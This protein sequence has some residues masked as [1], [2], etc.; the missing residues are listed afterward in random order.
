MNRLSFIALAAALVAGAPAH[1][2]SSS[3]S[4][5]ISNLSIQLF[6]LDPLDGI[7]PSIAFGSGS[8]DSFVSASAYQSSPYAYDYHE[9]WGTAFAPI[10]TSAVAGGTQS[11]A[12]I[13]GTGSAAGTTLSASGSTVVS[14]SSYPYD[15]GQYGAYAY[16]PYYYY[17]AFTLSA[18]T[19][20]VISGDASVSAAVDPTGSAY[21]YAYA[22]AYASLYISGPAA[23]G[24][25]GGQS[26]SDSRQAYL[27]NYATP[28]SFAD[29]GKIAVSFVNLTGLE[30]TGYFQGT[31]SAYG[32]AYAAAVPEPSGYAL[33][34]AGLA[35]TGFVARR[36]LRG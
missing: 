4:A 31:A 6:D 30:T 7:A 18:N 34:L 13:I 15:N 19:V 8:T 32:W 21:G 36:R 2:G 16:T 10:A 27:Y 9:A 23:G 29:A 12:A 24:G 35:A 11:Q 5:T 3:A 1:A 33:M 28:G 17:G 14:A 25:S 26:S 22:T 20:V